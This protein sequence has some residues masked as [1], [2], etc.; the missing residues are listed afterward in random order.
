[1]K[2]KHL[3]Q[4]IA[5]IGAVGSLP[6]FAAETVEKIEVTGTNIKRISKEGPSPVQV[7][8]REDIQRTGVSSTGELLRSLTA[9]SGLS[10]DDNATNS[11]AKGTS[12]VSL[13]GLGQKATLTLVNG[14]RM[15]SYG[16]AQNITN[17]FVDL[18]S[19][20]VGAI[21]RI[22]VLKGG[23]SAIYGSD[24][25]AGVINVV[26]RRDYQGA[27][28]GAAYGS[29]EKGDGEEITINA[30]GGYGS[31]SEDRFNVMG[32][33][34]YFKREP[35][36]LRD[37]GL[38]SSSDARAYGGGDKR[39]TSGNPGTY[40][41]PGGAT[42]ATDLRGTAPM[43][44]CPPDRMVSGYCRYDFNRDVVA[45]PETERAG[46]FGRA[47]FS[48]NENLS[49][50]GEAAYSRNDT[51]TIAAPSPNNTGDII[52]RRG[53]PNNPYNG[54]VGLLYRFVEAGNRMNDIT[55]DAYR[56]LF[57]VKGNFAKFDYEAGVSYAR[58]E[59]E[60]LGYNYINAMRVR[61]VTANGSYNYLNPYSNPASLIDSL[62]TVTSRNGLS[63][64]KTFDAKISGELVEL[65]A[66][67]LAM[68]A[69]VDY[70]RE[71]A[72]DSRDPLSAAGQI[73][74]SG[75]SSAKGER[76]VKAAFLEFNVP[77]H[78]TLELQLAARYD[79]YSN[80]A[81]G[82]ETSPKVALRWQPD[83]TML[84][85]ASYAEGFRAPSLQEQYLGATTSFNSGQRDPVRCPVTNDAGT[86]CAAQY[87][88]ISGGN[89]NLKPE[90]SKSTNVGFVLEPTNNISF[91]MEYYRIDYKDEISSIPVVD[92]L[93]K[94]E[95][96]GHLIH[97]LAPTPEDIARGL[98]GRID[99]ISREYINTASTKTRGLDFDLTLRFDLGSAGRL[100]FK[101][102]ATYVLSHKTRTTIT[103][104]E[105]ED[106]GTHNLPRLHNSAE[107]S[108]DKGDLQS[109]VRI[110]TVG[111]FAQLKNSVPA[112]QPNQNIASWTTVDAQVGYR[113]IK[114]LKLTFGIK[115]LF[116]R[117]P[118]L[119]YS[120]SSNY[121]ISQHNIRG[122]Y[123]YGRINYQF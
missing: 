61:E 21:E 122:R 26:L 15:A 43:P 14:R 49:L 76:N 10:L 12:G 33:F 47:T 70:R 113:V 58:S 92:I 68:A 4:A 52:L 83:K 116:D 105:T 34:D 90:S 7:I 98:P 85:R 89:L 112:S 25:I 101:D 23:A 32:T 100:T 28:V 118:P 44:T 104:Q 77:L 121:N 41:N 24:A 119:D 48:V 72:N 97:R 35:V 67:P 22:D 20:P 1:M 96:Y 95:T 11:F 46:F 16:F 109:T 74:G 81:N 39:S 91:G 42:A 51:L 108:W 8:R 78:S 50:F 27:E 17:S 88:V 18:N 99:Y 13:R 9:N 79:K 38:S 63:T 56:A 93:A 19:I 86:D 65:P 53:H 5:L 64:M 3:A 59:T 2:L 114:P 29:S 87:K 106:L 80:I 6:A 103:S 69:G 54:D 117:D 82:A 107:L 111:N 66:G 30:T 36:F 57:G 40:Y 123:Y 110:N 84:F 62:K 73:I 75:G 102:S 60:E 115:N 55:T 31:L 94:P 71:T 45:I 37:R 120:D